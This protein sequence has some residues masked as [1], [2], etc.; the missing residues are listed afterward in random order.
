MRLEPSARICSATRAWAPA[1][2][3]TMAMTAP[4]PMMMPSM[5]SEL[6]RGFTRRARS[7]MR[8]EER[9]ITP[10]VSALRGND[11]S[12]PSFVSQ[13]LDGVE[14]RGLL[15]GIEAEEDADGGG[16]AEGEENGLGVDEDAPLGEVGDGVGSRRSR[17]RCR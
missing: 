3:D 13:G 9:T 4:T 7:A 8:T 6:R 14:L 10:W 16:E 15:R 17:W 2:T 5:V 12:V 1:P 11:G